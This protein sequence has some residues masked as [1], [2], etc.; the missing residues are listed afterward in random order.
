M[1]VVSSDV[2][3]KVVRCYALFLKKVVRC[4]VD[5]FFIPMH[6]GIKKASGGRPSINRYGLIGGAASNVQSTGL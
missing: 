3:Q 6:T 4:Y 2:T 5:N 1:S